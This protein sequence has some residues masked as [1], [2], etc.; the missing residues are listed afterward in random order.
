MSWFEET[1]P[2]LRVPNS[3][4]VILTL[5]VIFFTGIGAGLR[6]RWDLPSGQDL[7]GVE[8]LDEWVAP[9]DK[10]VRQ[11]ITIDFEIDQSDWQAGGAAGPTTPCYTYFNSEPKQGDTGVGI[12]VGGEDITLRA[13]NDGV[14]WIDAYGGT[15]F[16]LIPSVLRGSNPEV[17][18]VKV[19][20]WDNDDTLDCLIK[21]DLSRFLKEQ[22]EYQPTYVMEM[23]L[24][25]VDVADLDDDNPADQRA[26]GTAQ[27]TVTVT[28]AYS[29]VTAEDGYAISELYVLSNDTV[30]GN[31]ITFKDMTVSGT[32]TLAQ[33][34]S[35]LDPSHDSIGGAYAAYYVRTHDSDEPLDPENLILFRDTNMG[36]TVYFS[37]QIVCNFETNDTVLVDITWILCSP[38]GTQATETDQVLLTE[39]A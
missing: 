29:G 32:H 26:I 27:T 30:K 11:T 25:N 15:D 24:L 31:D 18:L 4:L 3:W 19:N 1:N 13:E 38:D 37:V 12:T 20:D 8:D 2:W 35:T 6:A 36:D 14:I 5:F 33:G 16:Y 9:A 23:P 21:L 34:G 28:W 17:L 10:Y 39:K 22:H 7:L